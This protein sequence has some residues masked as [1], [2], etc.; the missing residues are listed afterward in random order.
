MPDFFGFNGVSW[1]LADL[2]F[3]YFLTP[4]FLRPAQKTKS[5][6]VMLFCLLL[7]R[8]FAEYITVCT[9]GMGIFW[10]IEIHTN[11][12]VRCMEFGIGLFLCPV[13][14]WALYTP[15]R[16]EVGRSS[17][18]EPRS[19]VKFTILET[20]AISALTYLL[21]SKNSTWYRFEYILLFVPFLLIFACN[22]GMISHILGSRPFRW[23]SK[24]QYEFFMLHLICIYYS[25][26]FIHAEWLPVSVVAF[27]LTL[28]CAYYYRYFLR[29]VFEKLM[30][31][32]YWK[33]LAFLGFHAQL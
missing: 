23:F 8:C 13:F 18:R 32:V 16:A 2:I 21:I 4:L 1:F 9:S 29:D 11:P 27:L 26:Y 22:R 14:R 3:C 7:L 5:A 24:I 25:T 6:A 28:G 30:K 17:F 12:I 20:F 33:V 15:T 31:T 19:V 10:H